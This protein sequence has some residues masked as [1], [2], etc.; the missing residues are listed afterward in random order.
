MFF[1]HSEQLIFFPSARTVLK[2]F[3]SD[4][5]ACFAI[6]KIILIYAKWFTVRLFY[7]WEGE[8][9]SSVLLIDIRRLLTKTSLNAY[10]EGSASIFSAIYCMGYLCLSLVPTRQCMPRS[11]LSLLLHVSQFTRDWSSIPSPRQQQPEPRPTALAPPCASAASR[12]RPY[13]PSSAL[14][15]LVEKCVAAHPAPP[16]FIQPFFA[17]F[18][19]ITQ[20]PF[21]SHTQNHKSQGWLSTR[22]AQRGAATRPHPQRQRRNSTMMSL[23]II[24][25]RLE[26]DRFDLS[27][28]SNSQET[29]HYVQK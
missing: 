10:V 22:G 19:C 24:I 13:S 27:L 16:P 21:G 26:R 15:Q 4:D 5:Y 28:D 17:N 29:L 3:P 18:R 2:Y 8:N 9:N 14:P 1:R 7:P 23:C 12:P 20:R 11:L 25:A 6:Y